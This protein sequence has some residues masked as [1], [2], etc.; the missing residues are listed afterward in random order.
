MQHLGMTKPLDTTTCNL[1]PLYYHQINRTIGNS[2][3]DLNICLMSLL[4][5]HGVEFQIE[6]NN[7]QWQNIPGSASTPGNPLSIAFANDWNTFTDIPYILNHIN[8]IPV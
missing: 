7:S 2:S 1:N 6:M 8:E 5:V 3:V 4:M